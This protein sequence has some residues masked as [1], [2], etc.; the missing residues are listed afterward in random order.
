MSIRQSASPDVLPDFRNLGVMARIL[1]GVNAAA[2]AAAAY[3]ESGW[4][5]IVER[6]VRDAVVV[7]PALIFSVFLLYVAAPTLRRLGY[8]AG[9]AAVAAAAL[10]L[11]TATA[12]IAGRLNPLAVATDVAKLW[13]FTLSA[14]AVLL[15]YLRLRTRAFSPALVEARLQALQARIRPHF[16]FNTLN[17]VLSVIRRDPQR[18]EAALEDLAELFRSLI[19]DQR[20]FVRLAD[21][22]ALLERYANLEQLRLGER[23]RLVW[24]IDGA[25]L[26]ALLPPLLLQPLLEN[27]VYHGI[28]PGTEPGEVVVNMALQG[29]Q[30]RLRMSNPYHREHQHRAGNRM[31]LANIR[32]RLMLFFDA[33]ARLETRVEGA[34][35][36]VAIEM[37]YLTE[38]AD[39]R[40]GSP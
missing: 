38:R 9:C 2:L 33:E 15:E 37:P 7:E 12:Y 4:P 35:Y 25:P 8:L 5:Q 21:E 27:A 29:N 31:A 1:V 11:A 16:L 30:V 18:A 26:D 36:V 23:L 17:A 19:S 3:A 34:R 10:A 20:G 22:I 24:E 6:F 14:T 13:L 28:E 39:Q 40:A 32:E